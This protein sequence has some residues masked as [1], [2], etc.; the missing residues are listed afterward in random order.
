V[1]SGGT[2]VITPGNIS[3]TSGNAVSVSPTATASYTLTVTATN[4]TQAIQSA[5]VTVTPILTVTPN[6][7]VIG[8]Q[9]QFTAAPGGFGTTSTAVTWSVSAPSGSSLSAGD[10]SSTG[11]YNTP[12]PAPA[13]VSVTATSTALPAVSGNVTVTLSSPATATGPALAVDINTPNTPSE[14]PH[15]INPYVYGMGAWALDPVSQATA[16]PSITRWGG[17]NTSRYNYKNT[18]SNTTADW[19]FENIQ[20]AGLEPGDGT[21]NSYLSTVHAGGA[22]ALGTVPV[23]GWVANGQNACGFSQSAFPN[24]AGPS[25]GSAFVSYNNEMCGYGDYPD[26][27]NGCTASNGC[28]ILVYPTTADPTA[29]ITEAEVT[30]IPI[31]P[32]D[33]TDASSTPAPGSSPSVMTAWANSTWDGGWVNTLVNTP[34]IGPASSSTGVQVWN[35]DN[36]PTWWSGTLRDVHPFAFTYDEVTNR[37]IGSALAVKTADPSAQI[38]GPVIDYWWGY[39][40]SMQDIWAGWDAGPCFEPWSSPSDREAHGGTPLIEYYLQQF[41]KYSQQYGIRLLDYVDI[42]GYFAPDFP[43]GSGTTV[44][45]TTAGDTQEQIVRLNSTRVFW[46]AT[47]TDP[48]YTQPNYI[49]DANYTSN[50]AVP[51]QAPQVIPMLKSWVA[52][53]Y[54]GTKTSIDEYNFGGLESINGAVT[55]ADILG[56]FGREGLD[57]GSFWPSTNDDTQQQPANYSFAMYR[58]YDGKDS[59]FGDVYLWATSTASGADAEGQ[60]SVYGAQR[61]SDGA[62]TVMVINKTFGSLTSTLTLE[63]FAASSNTT[64][65]VYQYSNANLNAIAQQPAVTVAPPLSGATSSTIGYTFP[66]QSIT[67]FVIPN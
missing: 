28:A 16:N 59:A 40:Y 60:L 38:S 35:L 45:F 49:T 18:W 30:S 58:N 46:D 19:Y 22:A 7:A 51:L 14:N 42:H 55:Q 32:P 6:S 2:G 61:S 11:L 63:N 67:L 39:F 56:I 1:F 53:D 20:G 12:Y 24:Q 31:Y 50:C 15:A 57:L 29:D 26:G 64:A 13:T 43:A 33:I 10:I 9:Q 17:D 8:T 4:G 3:A 44:A 62:I 52:N 5:A 54:P 27:Y 48:N 36:E 65:Q 66:A 47:Y 21:F 25:G 23:N 41:N 37:G 34:G